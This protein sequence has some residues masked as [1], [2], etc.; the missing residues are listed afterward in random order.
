[1]KKGAEQRMEKG[2]EA[3]VQEQLSALS[4]NLTRVIRYCVFTVRTESCGVVW[5]CCCVNV[6]QVCL[7]ACACVA[8]LMVYF[9]AGI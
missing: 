4:V 1:M 7:H 9:R 8:D 6:P 3:A 5:R 2:V